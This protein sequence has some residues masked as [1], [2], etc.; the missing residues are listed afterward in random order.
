VLFRSPDAGGAERALHIQQ[1]LRERLRDSGRTLD[2]L[3]YIDRLLR[4]F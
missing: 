2:E 4:R 3:Q 1:E